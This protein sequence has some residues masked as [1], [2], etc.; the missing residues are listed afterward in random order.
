MRAYSQDLRERVAAAC[1]LPGAKIY[2]VAALVSVS[3]SFVDK[4]LARQR[5]SGSV[6][7]LP[8]RGGRVAHLTE[9]GQRE[10]TL[11]LTQQPAATLEELRAA[12]ARSGGPTLSRTSTW[13][14]V[15]QAGWGRKKK[16]PRQRAGRRLAPRLSR[17]PGR[18]RPHSLPIWGRYSGRVCGRATWWCATIWP[19]IRWRAWPKFWLLTGPASCIGHP[20]R[21][22]L[23]PS[24][25]PSASSKPGCARPRRAPATCS[26]K[27]AARRS[28]G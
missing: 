21:P 18:G 4:L 16:R 11:C 8:A 14:A 25:L 22:I 7:R 20:V 28:S 26:K 6:A 13:R 27:P 1:A 5:P 17:S 24:N 12:L 9:A 3:I 23:I 15:E 19:R 2:Q 10:L